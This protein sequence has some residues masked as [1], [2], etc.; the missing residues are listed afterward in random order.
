MGN[1]SVS[2]I[3]GGRGRREK[4]ADHCEGIHG[5]SAICD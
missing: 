4:W 1:L 5:E 3:R 2:L